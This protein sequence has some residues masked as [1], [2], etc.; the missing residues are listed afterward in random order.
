MYHIEPFIRGS[1]YKKPLK[2]PKMRTNK[3]DRFQADTMLNKVFSWECPRF[4]RL[5]ILHFLQ[6]CLIVLRQKD[7]G[8]FDSYRYFHYADP[9]E[10]EGQNAVMAAI[11]V[12]AKS[13]P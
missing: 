7:R 10:K 11:K 12:R 6:V 4:L 2:M 3:Y 5:K 13:P 1:I 8:L 9:F